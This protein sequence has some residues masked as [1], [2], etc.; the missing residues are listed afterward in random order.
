MYQDQGLGPATLDPWLWTHDSDPE[1]FDED[2]I[3]YHCK[4]RFLG[5]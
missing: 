5:W 3:V 4:I 1:T 2:I